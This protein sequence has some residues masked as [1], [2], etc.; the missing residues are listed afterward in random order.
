MIDTY[1]KQLAKLND[2]KEK[3][4]TFQRKM[5]EMIIQLS[6]LG[7][8]VQNDNVLERLTSKSLEVAEKQR[9]IDLI[10]EEIQK[11]R[12]KLI[13]KDTLLKEKLKIV[14]NECV[15]QNNIIE[16]CNRNK[17]NYSNVQEQVELIREINREFKIIVDMY[18]FRNY[19]RIIS[20]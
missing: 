20:N 7:V 1:E 14:Q 18:N 3:L 5:Q 16:S 4:E 8:I 10:K 11:C 17:M 12:D 2:E 19:F 15:E 9:F 6:E 13:E